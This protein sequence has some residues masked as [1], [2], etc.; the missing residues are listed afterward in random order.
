M[1][2][3]ASEFRTDGGDLKGRPEDQVTDILARVEHN[4]NDLVQGLSLLGVKRCSWCKRFFRSS[5]P[6]ALF[7]SG[8]ELVC[9]GCIPAWWP[10][11]RE[12]LSCEDIQKAEGSLVFWLRGH[13]NAYL[14]KN[15]RKPNE[16]QPVKFELVASCLECRGS[17]T[18]MGDRRCRYCD[19][20]GAVRV[21]VPEKTR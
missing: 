18:L 10:S 3:S 13:H 1:H 4:L 12:Q 17:G 2:Q 15:S 6:G 7:S 8:R 19:G 21:I 20:P 16:G 5:D 14:Q 11:R 9:L